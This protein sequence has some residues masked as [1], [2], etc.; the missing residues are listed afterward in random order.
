LRSRLTLGPMPETMVVTSSVMCL[1]L[2]DGLRA[3]GCYD[4]VVHILND[5]SS[6]RELPRSPLTPDDNLYNIVDDSH[7]M[8][9][10]HLLRLPGR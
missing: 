7:P 5:I 8:V 4:G 6:G 1:R 3:S 2:L 9:N 10:A